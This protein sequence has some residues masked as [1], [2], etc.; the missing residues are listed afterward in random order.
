MVVLEVGCGFFRAAIDERTVN[1]EL[2]SLLASFTDPSHCVHSLTASTRSLDLDTRNLRLLQQ[3]HRPQADKQ[4]EEAQDVR[5][6]NLEH[7]HHDNLEVD[8]GKRDRLLVEFLPGGEEQK[9]VSHQSQNGQRHFDVQVGDDGQQRGHD[10]QNGRHER[11]IFLRLVIEFL[12]W[13][14]G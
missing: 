11:V 6:D 10:H 4:V 9:G 2:F 5:K 3:P 12:W 1:V 8:V 14:V 7:R 13:H